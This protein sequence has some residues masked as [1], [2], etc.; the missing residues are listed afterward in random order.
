MHIENR[1][2]LASRDVKERLGGVSDMTI[3]RWQHDPELDFPKPAVVR[4]RKYWAAA[5]I[6]AFIERRRAAA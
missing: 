5:E 6:E 4:K 1:K 3:W 2:L